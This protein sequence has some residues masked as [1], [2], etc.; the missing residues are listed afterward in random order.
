MENS[1]YVKPVIKRLV[2]P[3]TKEEVDPIRQAGDK[4]TTE[5]AALERE[6][7]LG[8]K[9]PEPTKAPAPK[10]DPIRQAGDKRAT[11]APK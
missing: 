2:R 7:V 10:V 1:R 9:K 8:T 6:R 5:A 3:V 4:R 11:E